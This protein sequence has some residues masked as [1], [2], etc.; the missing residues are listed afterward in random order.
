MMIDFLENK[1]R[2][3]GRKVWKKQVKARKQAKS[4]GHA[5]IAGF[6]RIQTVPSTAWACRVCTTDSTGIYVLGQ[7]RCQRKEK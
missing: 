7:R 2:T 1:R 6:L 5:D 4:S 3:N